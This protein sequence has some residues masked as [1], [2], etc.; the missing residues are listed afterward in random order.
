LLN[1]LLGFSQKISLGLL[2]SVKVR[3]PQGFYFEEATDS[4]LVFFNGVS[5]EL[6]LYNFENQLFEKI[7][8]NK[9]LTKT[10]SSV[11]QVKC[12]RLSF[13]HYSEKEKFL[14]Y[15]NSGGSIFLYD[16]QNQEK[17]RLYS[18]IH[19]IQSYT[20]FDTT[21][22]IGRN[23]NQKKIY[24]LAIYEKKIMKS[25][26]YSC[27]IPINSEAWW[28]YYPYYY[29]TYLNDTIIGLQYNFNPTI[30]LYHTKYKDFTGI[31]HSP[32]AI[33]YNDSI[34]PY[35]PTKRYLKWHDNIHFNAMRRN[36]YMP[37]KR[38]E[39]EGMI[40]FFQNV[41]LPNVQENVTTIFE[42]DDLFNIHLS[43]FVLFDQYFNPIYLSSPTHA[44]F[45]ALN[46]G[47]LCSWYWDKNTKEF[48]IT[49]YKL[50][51]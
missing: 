30:F 36:H 48:V 27:N 18:N 3:V 35:F 26:T 40:L 50:I 4:S 9:N 41:L 46:S 5:E 21:W 47:L 37:I 15:R 33:V 31:V 10:H 25:E 8:I 6:L 12:S 13:I 32:I 24:R 22:L 42:R 1:Q 11:G 51:F 7:S 38:I 34:Q 39:I 43:Q 28:F 2:D 20:K 44:T 16:I 29:L 45:I 17:K 23:L 19:G 49:R 14:L